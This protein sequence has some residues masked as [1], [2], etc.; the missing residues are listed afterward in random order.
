MGWQVALILDHETEVDRFLSQMPVWAV[1]TEAR[2]DTA[3]E[4][5]AS[6]DALWDP[7]PALTLITR[8]IGDDLTEMAD[9]VPTLHEHHPRL[10]CIRLVGVGDSDAFR[11]CMNSLGYSKLPE[12]DDFAL[13]FTRPVEA[14]EHVPDLPLDANGW[15]T[16]DDLY[17]A[18]FHAVG[19]P[20]WHGRNFDAVNDSVSTGNINRVEVPYRLAIQNLRKAE[21]PAR[22]MVRRFAELID[23]IRS[24]GC[25]VSITLQE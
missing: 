6:W 18:F 2:R 23:S 4:L 9:L 24:T 20:S 8:A 16:A 21:E 1:S 25:P 17:D 15:K 3:Q 14:L 22:E 12:T 10:A 19:A 7:E 13:S 11:E 5:R